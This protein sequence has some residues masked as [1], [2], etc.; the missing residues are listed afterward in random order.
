MEAAAQSDVNS[1]QTAATSPATLSTTDQN[2]DLDL[3][4]DFDLPED[5]LTDAPSPAPVS[6]AAVA[7][8]A[9]TAGA[10]TAALDS[11]FAVSEAPA[12]TDDL[13]LPEPASLPPEQQATPAWAA[14]ATPA[15]DAA[16][17][18]ALS[19]PSLA[20]FDFPMDLPPRDVAPAPAS[21]QVET[22]TAEEPFVLP[23]SGLMEFNLDD[24]S[25]DLDTPET[26][27]PTSAPADAALPDD[28]LATKLALAQEFN[29]IGDSDG[30]RTLIEEVIAEASGDL[31]A[32][33]QKMLS[34]LG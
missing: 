34:E 2:I 7:A 17:A 10:A 11:P 21:E 14:P 26:S 19:L 28:P 24:L 3:D 29:T 5:A 9:A 1:T 33:A 12:P 8:T 32:R 30:A 15:P 25:L 22:A 23:E 31:K 18:P 13:E 4:L 20:D 6:F 27:S 16:T